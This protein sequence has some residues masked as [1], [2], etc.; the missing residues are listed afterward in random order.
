ML[1]KL[2]NN[3]GF[4]IIEVMIVLAVAALIILIVLLAVPALQRSSRNTA[5]KNDAS[6]LASGSST[7]QSNND[8]AMP[9]VLTQNGAT[10]T[11]CKALSGTG[12]ASGDAPAT[13]KVQ[14][15]DTVAGSTYTDATTGI[16]SATDASVGHINVIFGAACDGN[17]ALKQ[18]P[19]STAISYVI[20]GSGSPAQQ[21][22]DS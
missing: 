16:L 18:S 21:C 6:A 12:C 20:E 10:V 4:T 22:V 19:R 8:G 3:Q 5:I 11:F 17:A 1:K 7:Y 15:S 13:V 9:Q 14:G 2:K